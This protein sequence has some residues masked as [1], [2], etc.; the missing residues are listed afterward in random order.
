MGAFFST[1]KKHVGRIEV[2]GSAENQ[3]L[4]DITQARLVVQ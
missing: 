3:S 1:S 4:A 2:I